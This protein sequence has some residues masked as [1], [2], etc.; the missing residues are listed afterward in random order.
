MGGGVVEE[1]GR[2]RDRGG[3]PQQQL[4][5]Q[6]VSQQPSSLSGQWLVAFMVNS[7][8]QVPEWRR[9]ATSRPA[10]SSPCRSRQ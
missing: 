2:A 3:S 4:P 6:H 8:Q 9:S 10:R 5:P 1:P 7:F